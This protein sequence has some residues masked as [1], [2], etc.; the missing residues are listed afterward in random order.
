MVIVADKFGKLLL[1]AKLITEPQL[2]E[3]MAVMKQKG[4]GRLG[5]TLVKL[6][7]IDEDKL[8]GFLAQQYRVQAVDLKNYPNIDPAII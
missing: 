6:G 4:G 7:F 1:G 5:S 2:A 3:A 8:L